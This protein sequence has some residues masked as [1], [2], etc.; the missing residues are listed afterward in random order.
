MQNL[1]NWCVS[2]IGAEPIAFSYNSAL[3]NSNK[4]LW[5]KEFT[6]A[7]SSGSQ[8]QT[9][10]STT[11]I[12]P[13]QYLVS[14][15]CSTTLSISASN[16]PSGVSAFLDDVNVAYISGTPAGT[17]TGTFNYSLIISGSTT[18]QTVTG[19]ITVSSSASSTTTST[20]TST[21][22][23]SA[24]FNFPME[25]DFDSNG[26]MF[27]V[28][29]LNGKIRKITP[30]G[31]VSTFA[32]DLGNPIAL[33]IDS[34]DNVFVGRN[35]SLSDSSNEILK[36]TP[37][38][39]VSTF[40]GGSYGNIDANGTNAQFKYVHSIDFDSNENLIVTDGNNHSIRK[41]TPQGDVTTISTSAAGTNYQ[42]PQGLKFDSSKNEIYIADNGNHRI[43]KL[44]Y[45]GAV[46]S[47]SV[48]RTGSSCND[49]S[50]VALAI[51]SNNKIYFGSGCGVNKIYSLNADG[52][53][54][55]FSSFSGKGQFYL[56]FDSSDN[57][58]LADTGDH[59]IYKITPQGTISTF[60]GS[61][62]GDQDSN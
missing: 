3:T 22:S 30:S 53:T 49:G 51:D 43:V 52:T 31:I 16:L 45:N 47:S 56:K 7:L 34:N 37:G 17:A 60:A 35:I 29:R 6:I 44:D 54:S 21:T 13:I 42:G 9:V 46:S 5:G 20:S 12:T 15:I 58:Y 55:F 26:N 39:T 2:N 50:P 33:S 62:V 61:T 18:S 23:S 40:V 19:T 59:K 27:V 36:I 24:K 10:T 41:I 4:P 1:S 14:S 38:G 28:D 11:S 8:T 48:V 32:S 57:L 25:M